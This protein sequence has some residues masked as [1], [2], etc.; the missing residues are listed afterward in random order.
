M[1]TTSVPSAV[2]L[3]DDE[4]SLVVKALGLLSASMRRSAKS[5][6]SKEISDLFERDAARVDALAVKFR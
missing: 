4:R 1:A 6:P 3:S 5:A 2:S